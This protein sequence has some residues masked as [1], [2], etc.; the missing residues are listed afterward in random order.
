MAE[1][2]LDVVHV[3]AAAQQLGG[4]ASAK[5][6]RGDLAGNSG[7]LGVGVHVLQKPG[8]GHAGAP[9]GE[10]ERLFVF[11][12]DDTAS[13]VELTL[14]NQKRAYGYDIAFQKPYGSLAHRHHA[15]LVAFA[16][17]EQRGVTDVDVPG[18]ES[19]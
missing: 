15:F 12:Q 17:D 19:Q 4:T 16:M 13:Q 9:A 6:M 14:L 1:E 3:G 5:G 2:V 7:A 10:K 11:G 8:I 18:V